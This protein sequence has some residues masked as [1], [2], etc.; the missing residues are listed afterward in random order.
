MSGVAMS[1]CVAGMYSCAYAYGS[2]MGVFTV[3][4]LDA[5]P[6]NPFGSDGVG[7]HNGIHLQVDF[8]P[9]YAQFV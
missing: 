1:Y 2:L 7:T 3:D 9:V 8:T 4:V 5:Y 6:G